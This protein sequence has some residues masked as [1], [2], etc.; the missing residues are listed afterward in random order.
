LIPFE[1]LFLLFIFVRMFVEDWHGASIAAIFGCLG[2]IAAMYLAYYLCTSQPDFKRLDPDSQ[3]WMCGTYQLMAMPL[4]ALAIMVLVWLAW[5]QRYGRA[6]RK[7]SGS[8]LDSHRAY[9]GMI[10]GAVTGSF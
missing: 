10:S 9:V 5:R 7:E 1:C 4:G 3:G 6:D 8:M 2:A